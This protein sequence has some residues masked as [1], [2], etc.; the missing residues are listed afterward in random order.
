MHM[1]RLNQPT[2]QSLA[3]ALQQG[4]LGSLTQIMKKYHSPLLRYANY[5]GA[6]E[7]DED[8][9]QETFIKVYKNIQGYDPSKAFSSWIYRI[10]HNTAISMIRKNKFSIP[11]EEYLDNFVSQDPVDNIDK[12]LKKEQ[13]A[14]CIDQLPLHYKAPLAL[15]YME[16]KTYEEIMD[17]LRLPRGTVAARINRAKKQMRNLCQK[18]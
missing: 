1:A 7:S 5:L 13:V 12:D 14:K 18:N 17:I 15:Y 10:A 4:D 9:V 3:I 2:D 16:D 6:G 8:V 11:W